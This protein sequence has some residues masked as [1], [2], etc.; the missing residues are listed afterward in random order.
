MAE[1]V[2]PMPALQEKVQSVLDELIATG[3][4]TGLQVA[5]YRYGALV[6]DAVAGL[7]DSQTERPVT[8][9]TPFFSFS[10]GKV[11][12]ATVAHLLVRIGALRY[13]TP[14]V[15]LW[16]E[17]GAHGKATA[18]LR[19]VLTHSV[20]VP[21]MPRVIGPADLADWSRVCGAIADAEP[22]W[23]PGTRTGYH[24]FTF[25][26]LV[27]E[28]ARRATGE[29]MRHLLH[30]W[31]SDPLGLD[32]D[33][34][35]G[36]SRTDLARL[37]RLEDSAPPAAASDAAGVLAPWERQPI[38]AM[39][40]SADILQADIPSVGTFTAR[41]I[42]AMNA[43]VLDGRLIDADQLAELTSPAFEGT[44]QVFGNHTR[45]ALGYPLG[46]IGTRPEETPTTFGWV[47]GGGSYVYADTATGTSF[48]MTKTRLTPHF[49]TAQRL[50]DLVAAE[51]RIDT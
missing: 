10:A 39:G 36:V 5:V 14:L 16:P 7:A 37:A 29:P 21:A 11:M 43:A 12:T 33:L 28:A 8:S 19:H 48:A 6:V 32:G 15:D 20:G 27:G 40:N 50:A 25:G 1:P 4:E 3:A 2:T 41:G 13:D 42:A 47:G 45:L 9:Q 44:D 51:L 23:R 38:A 46:R 22:R 17:F 18:T 24:A 31:V 35:F 30:K 26:F 49:N 34:F